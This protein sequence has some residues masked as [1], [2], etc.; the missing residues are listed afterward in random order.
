MNTVTA[1]EAPTA[2]APIENPAENPAENPVEDPAGNTASGKPGQGRLTTHVLED[3]PGQRYLLYR[4]AGMHAHSPLVI[5]VHGISR[6][7]REQVESFRREA[8][9]H[10]AVL[11][12]PLFT[13]PEFRDFQ[14]LGRRGRGVRADLALLDMIQA[15]RRM[16]GIAASPGFLFGYSGGGQFVHR[17]A[18]AWPDQVARIAVGAAGW[19][20][21]PDLSRRY[22]YGLRDSDALPG[23]R[24]DLAAIL[25]IPAL[26][27]VG[28]WD[29]ERDPAFKRAPHLDRIQGLTRIERGRR[30]ATAMREAARQRNLQT[31]Y[32]FEILPRCGH[33]FRDNMRQG[34]GKRVFDFFFQTEEEQQQ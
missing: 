7:G 1:C 21:F 6:N 31:V 20:T 27:L 34:M 29:T 26:V 3:R 33:S 18:M 8:E 30:W 15:V 19:Y 17:F 28:E 9:R 11:L 12:A 32:R 24:F 25:R 16:T 14:R 10:D 5:V 23:V 13:R 22:P 2:E 4:P